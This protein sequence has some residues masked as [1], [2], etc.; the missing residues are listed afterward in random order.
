MEVC[1]IRCVKICLIA[2]V[3]NNRI[4]IFTIYRSFV[5]VVVDVVIL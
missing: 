1:T 2:K 5:V 4:G 3:N